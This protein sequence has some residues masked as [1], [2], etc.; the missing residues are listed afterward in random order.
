MTWRIE[1]GIRL[2]GQAFLDRRLEPMLERFDWVYLGSEF[3]E[4]LLEP[5][6]GSEAT[7][8]QQMGK[9]VCLLTPLLTEKGAGALAAIFKRLRKLLAS[10]HLSADRFEITINDFGAL[11]LAAREKLPV[12]LNAGRQFCPNAFSSRARDLTVLNAPSLDFLA[13]YGITRYEISTTGHRPR[14]NFA[15]C[16]PFYRKQFSLT[17]Y[18]PYLPLATTRTCLVGMPDLG[19]EDPVRG[20]ACGRECRACTFEVVHPWIK[21]KLLVRGNTV[22]LEFPRKFYSSAEML[23]RLRVDRLVY[24]PFP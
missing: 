9:K 19:P 1:Q 5:G 16:G 20:I 2:S 11:E 7:R 17:L 14:T 6:L 23:K 8:L 12:R 24:S 15:P 21:E 13:R 22:F 3:C 18:Y 10:G 4:N